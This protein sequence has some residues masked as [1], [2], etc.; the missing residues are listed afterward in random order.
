M[1]YP[2]SHLIFVVAY[3]YILFFRGGVWLQDTHQGTTTKPQAESGEIENKKLFT[4]LVYLKKS[5]VH[6]YG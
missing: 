6:D 1:T 5:T 4:K 2:V 3:C